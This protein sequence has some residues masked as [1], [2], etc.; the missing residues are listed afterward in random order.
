MLPTTS[1][2]VAFV[3]WTVSVKIAAQNEKM[4]RFISTQNLADFKKHR[5][6]SVNSPS[7]LT[8]A[9]ECAHQNDCVKFRWENGICSMNSNVCDGGLCAIR[10]ML[11]L[12]ECTPTA[13]FINAKFGKKESIAEGHCYIPIFSSPLTKCYTT[14]TADNSQSCHDDVLQPSDRRGQCLIFQFIKRV[15]GAHLYDD[16]EQYI[17]QIYG[18]KFLFTDRNQRL[19]EEIEAAD[20]FVLIFIKFKSYPPGPDGEY[21]A[22][23]YCENGESSWVVNMV[24]TPCE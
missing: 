20:P 5:P 1:A 7:D 6:N 10:H 21:L 23:I 16:T 4:V 17:A 22:K 9:R 11:R 14:S 3:A 13:A 2:L 12:Y 18:T 19:V 24:E 15:R 8:C